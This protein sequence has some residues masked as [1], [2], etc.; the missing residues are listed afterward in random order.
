MKH[1]FNKHSVEVDEHS[2]LNAHS[3]GRICISAWIEESRVWNTYDMVI[4]L[5]SS[6]VNYSPLPCGTR[7]SICWNSTISSS[8][9]LA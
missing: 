4:T 7:Q 5:L 6:H 8:W 3:R 9:R 2:D 1:S